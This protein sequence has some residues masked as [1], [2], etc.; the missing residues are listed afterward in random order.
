MGLS[1][2]KKERTILDFVSDIEVFAEHLG[3]DTFSILA[4]S[5]GAAYALAVCFLIPHRVIFC[6]LVSA[7]PPVNE[8]DESRMLS[9]MRFLIKIAK[10]APWLLRPLLWFFHGR[11]VKRKRDHKKLVSNILF[12]LDE[13][14]KRLI[15]DEERCRFLMEIFTEG[16]RQGAKG[17]ATDFR[18]LANPWG[19]SLSEISFPFIRL[20]H[21]ERDRGVPLEMVRVMTY[22]LQGAVLKTYLNDGHILIIFD[23][24]PDMINDI[25]KYRN[26]KTHRLQPDY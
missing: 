23:H 16:Y 1:G 17:V 13:S 14:D 24:M 2:Y 22:K 9:E 3:I 26:E 6:G 25:E 21:G 8:I 4:V 12:Y 19:F 11:L 18:L 10:I 20:W 7:L 15:Q 5:G